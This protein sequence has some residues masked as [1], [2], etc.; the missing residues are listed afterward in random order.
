MFKIDEKNTSGL[1][2]SFFHNFCRVYGHHADFGCHDANVV[3]SNVIA[4]G[5]QAVAVENR[6]DAGAVRE[7]YGRR[8]IPRL[9]Q[10]GVVFVERFFL[11][12]H[13]CVLLPSLWNHHQQR[14]WQS[15]TR[16]QQEFQD[17]IEGAGVRAVRLNDGEQFFNVL[18]EVLRSHGS[19][20][21]V[22]G[23]D[24]AQ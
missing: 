17:V 11:C 8:S 6:A 12:G 2:P 13:A 22:H 20:P 10:A 16:H 23:I 1:Q 3:V 14:F 24:V 4:R 19:F 21:G 18:A 9:D 7:C 5:P 15:S